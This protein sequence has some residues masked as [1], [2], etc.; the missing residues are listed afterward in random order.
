VVTVVVAVL[1]VDGVL[2]LVLC[3]VLVLVP[4]LGVDALWEL[5]ALDDPL[6]G[7]DR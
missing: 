3:V 1:D 6:A 5:E 4:L 2:V 7:A